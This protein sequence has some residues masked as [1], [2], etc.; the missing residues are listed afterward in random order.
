MSAIF[1]VSLAS[2]I[3]TNNCQYEYSDTP[4]FTLRWILRYFW[5]SSKTP[6]WP[7]ENTKST[8]LLSLSLMGLSAGVSF[9]SCPPKKETVFTDI[10][11]QCV[12]LGTP[13]GGRSSYL[14]LWFLYERKPLKNHWPTD[15]IYSW[16]ECGPITP[17]ITFP[18][19]HGQLW[20]KEVMTGPFISLFIRGKY[21]CI[22]YIPLVLEEGKWPT[23]KTRFANSFG[24]LSGLNAYRF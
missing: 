16:R 9:N 22:S 19:L 18:S 15:G 21:L 20:R 4:L 11:I 23:W 7:T 8:F 24:K 6:R 14:A 12:P 2:F 5:A 13:S 10:P 3:F 17:E 1:C